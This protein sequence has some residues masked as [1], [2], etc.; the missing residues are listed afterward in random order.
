MWA[1]ENAEVVWLAMAESTV[2]LWVKDGR[3]GSGAAKASVSTQVCGK[4]H[5]AL[6]ALA[7]DTLADTRRSLNAKVWICHFCKPD[8]SYFTCI[9]SL[10]GSEGRPCITVLHWK[11]VSSESRL[12]DT[13][14]PNSLPMEKVVSL[15]PPHWPAFSKR[16]FLG[17]HGINVTRGFSLPKSVSDTALLF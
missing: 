16:S 10:A 13:H 8:T 17:L 9:P 12:L 14:T 5:R 1:S 15:L 3:R 6:P 7:A 4:A 11:V 2:K